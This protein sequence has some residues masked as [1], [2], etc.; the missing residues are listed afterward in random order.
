MGSEGVTQP[1]VFHKTLGMIAAANLALLQPYKYMQV[2][3][4]CGREGESIKLAIQGGNV[5]YE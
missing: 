3:I 5:Y 4:Q 2:F 1:E